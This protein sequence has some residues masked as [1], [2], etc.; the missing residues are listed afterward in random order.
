MSM[1]GEENRLKFK[2]TFILLIQKCFLLPT[3]MS[4]ISLVHMPA[5]L[6]TENTRRQNWAT[7]VLNFLIK[8]IK[9]NKNEEKYSIDKCLFAFM[10][11]YF[12]ESKFIDITANMMPGPPWV[13]Q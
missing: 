11:I 2:R 7:H 8:R 9:N 1:N 10:I 12:H 13:V 5:I 3:T 6:D 4:K